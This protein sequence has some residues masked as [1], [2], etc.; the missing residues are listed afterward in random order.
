MV[1]LLNACYE[2][3]SSKSLI[4]DN[5]TVLTVNDDKINFKGFKKELA[6]Q[7]KI[8]R[9]HNSQKLKPEELVWIKNRVLDELIK[10]TLLKQELTRNNITVDPKEID[11]ALNKAS[12]G[13]TKGS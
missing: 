12:E 8:F 13:Y 10:N 4:T 2:N 3:N 5:K 6:E 7:K 1:C 9:I 11:E